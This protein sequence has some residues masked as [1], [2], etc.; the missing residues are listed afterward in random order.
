MRSKVSSS[1]IPT[2]LLTQLAELVEALIPY[3]D[4]WSLNM[5]IDKEGQRVYLC[6]GGW[7]EY[8]GRTFKEILKKI[9]KDW[10]RVYKELP[11]AKGP[12]DLEY[13]DL[14]ER[15]ENFQ[16]TLGEVKKRLAQ[17]NAK[18]TTKNS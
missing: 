15:R 16:A 3:H 10:R 7:E 13:W 4:Q 5:R 6:D 14:Q 11:K 17:I 1:F 8:D 12:K 18:G 2:S 9:Q